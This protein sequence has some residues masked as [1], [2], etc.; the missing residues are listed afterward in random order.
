MT[1]AYDSALMCF[2]DPRRT[3]EENLICAQN[4]FENR[5]ENTTETRVSVLRNKL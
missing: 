5:F 3:L 4:R 2:G 1:N